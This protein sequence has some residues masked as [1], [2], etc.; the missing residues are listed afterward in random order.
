[1]IASS[2]PLHGAAIKILPLAIT[3]LLTAC[4]GGGGGGGSSGSTPASVYIKATNTEQSAADCLP[5]PGGCDQFGSA[6]A[7]SAAGDLLVVGAPFDDSDSTGINNA[8][9]NSA[10]GYNSGAVYTY[11]R[12]GDT[13]T[14]GD[15]LKA[16]NTGSLDNFGEFLALSDDGNTLAVGVP[17]EDSSATGID[18]DQAN[19]DRRG[20]GAV[21]V[22]VRD[23]SGDWSQQ[24]YIK[25]QVSLLLDGFGSALALSANGN[26]LAVG[27]PG[28]EGVYVYRRSAGAWDPA[29]SF[30]QASNSEP[31]DGFG[32]A[33]A[34]SDSGN[35]LAVGAPQESSDGSGEGDNAAANAGAAYVYTFASSVWSQQSYIKASMVAANSD[36]GNAVSLSAAGDKLAVGARYENAGATDAG[37]AYVYT[38]AA[39]VPS[40]EVRVIANVR[41]AGDQFGQRVA[42]TADGSALFVTANLE[43]GKATN[44]GGNDRDFYPDTDLVEP[45]NNADAGAAYRFDVAS[46]VPVQEAYIKAL[47]TGQGDKFGESLA[48]NADGTIYAIGAT[49]EDSSAKGVAPADQGNEAELQAGA[50]YLFQ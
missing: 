48:V 6:V 7:I 26:R 19:N 49:L 36:F 40:D 4:G 16:S 2:K 10:D 32:S 14:V 47:N 24:A 13:W 43:D 8:Q 45:F 21:Y 39:G 41:R 11:V 44:L 34:L 42:L 17:E 5:D 25:S 18:G 37:A 12:T 33:V 15:Y 9:G 27:A 29:P 1:M 30:I 28:E 35:T 20:S 3:A 22:Y 46:G 23:G 38:L 50:A 31:G